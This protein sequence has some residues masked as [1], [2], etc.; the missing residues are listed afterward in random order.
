M[1]AGE[2]EINCN[3]NNFVQVV[4]KSVEE[5]QFFVA[6]KK[7][8]YY[9]VHQNVIIHQMN[10][11]DEL[12]I[13]SL[14][15]NGIKVGVLDVG[16]IDEDNTNFDNIYVETRNAWYFIE[17][18][19]D[20]ATTMASCIGGREGIARQASIYSVQGAGNPSSE[21]DWLLDKGVHVVN[22]SYGY[23]DADGVYSSHSA[24]YDYMVWTYGVS[25]IAASGNEPSDE[26]D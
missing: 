23:G 6:N 1:D 16:I 25:V 5:I 7:H 20:H 11:R 22:C 24:T 26:H 21:L 18:V 12:V 8:M 19:S 17:S 3:K 15:G 10:V 9:L 4:H 2:N 14:T 13:G